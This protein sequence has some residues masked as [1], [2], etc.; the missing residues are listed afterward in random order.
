MDG[1]AIQDAHRCHSNL[2]RMA[3]CWL[4]PPM[5]CLTLAVKSHKT[6]SFVVSMLSD[7]LEVLHF[8][9]L[10]WTE[11]IFTLTSNSRPD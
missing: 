11:V 1:L 9:S 7:H 10:Y 8:W 6:V 2:L 4:L 3:L 5:I